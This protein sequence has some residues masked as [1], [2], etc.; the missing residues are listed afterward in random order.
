[1]ARTLFFRM[2]L[3]KFSE[4]TNSKPIFSQYNIFYNYEYF[5]FQSAFWSLFNHR[6]RSQLN[7]EQC[8]LGCSWHC[9]LVLLCTHYGP[10][11][12]FS[13][14]F[15]KLKEI[16]VI[17][18][19]FPDFVI[20]CDNGER[21]CIMQTEKVTDKLSLTCLKCILKISRSNYLF[22]V[23]LFHVPNNFLVIQV[24]S[25]IS[26]KSSLLFSICCCVFLFLNKGSLT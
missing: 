13:T 7:Q 16:G 11:Q 26:S 6:Q 19:I 21:Y 15:P 12:C 4:I 2:D 10:L 14:Y 1:M 9:F 8:S 20:S 17:R 3:R 23:Q 18:P 24:K 25:V 22:H 5:F